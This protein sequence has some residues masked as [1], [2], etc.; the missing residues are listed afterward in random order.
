M[1]GVNLVCCA[2]AGWLVAGPIGAMFGVG[3]WIVGW[4]ISLLI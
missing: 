4:I 3:A 1:F 2:A